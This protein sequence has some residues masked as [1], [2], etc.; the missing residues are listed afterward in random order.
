[1]PALCVG[2]CWGLLVALLAGGLQTMGCVVCVWGGGGGAA[3]RQGSTARPG[4]GLRLHGGQLA[5]CVFVRCA[6]VS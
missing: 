4:L 2:G 3:N 6:H 5:C 1:M